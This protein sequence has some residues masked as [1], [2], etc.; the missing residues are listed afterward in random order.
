MHSPLNYL[1]GKSKLAKKIVVRIPKDHVCYVEPFI[2]AGW[3]F[4]AKDPSRAEVINDKDG[5][6]VTFWRVIQHHLPAFLDYYRFAITSRKLFELENMKRPETLTDIQR[7]ARYFY[8]QRLSFGGKTAGRTFGTSATEPSRLNLTGIEER[9]LEVHWRLERVT[10]EHLD[11]IECIRRYDRPS[12]FFY[13]DPPY[14][15]LSQGYACKFADQDYIILRDALA[16]IK[17]RFLLSLNDHP[18]ILKLFAGFAVERVLLTYSAGNSRQAESTRSKARAELLISNFG[19]GRLS[20]PA[21]PPRAP[22]VAQ[23]SLPAQL[24]RGGHSTGLSASISGRSIPAQKSVSVAQK[25]Q[26]LACFEA[27][28]A[29]IGP[30][31]PNHS[32][33]PKV[34]RRL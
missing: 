24:R 4:F 11:A 7:A 23:K 31:L 3:V 17:G 34:T 19:P 8:L 29:E 30:E 27:C 22:T 28:F 2:G 26:V 15:R 6:L 9:L 32:G 5:E 1:G 14:Y 20:A 13:L 21:R 18:E 25:S 16:K 12:T 33:L 10:I